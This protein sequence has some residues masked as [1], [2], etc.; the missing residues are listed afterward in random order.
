M[1]ALLDLWSA[2]PAEFVYARIQR[3]DG[4]EL[5]TR[6]RLQLDVVIGARYASEQ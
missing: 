5:L 4:V 1:L 6:Y 2:S 3:A